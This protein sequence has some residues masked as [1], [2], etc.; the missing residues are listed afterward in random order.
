[1]PVSVSYLYSDDPAARSHYALLAR[2]IHL[3]E[4][5]IQDADLRVRAAVLANPTTP[6]RL[7]KIRPHM[8]RSE[9]SA[10]AR[11]PKTTQAVILALVADPDP[12]VRWFAKERVYAG[13]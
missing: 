4:I 11:N 12:W 5:L 6:P 9:R 7:L 2:P 1:M 3:P 13:R 10:L 8:H